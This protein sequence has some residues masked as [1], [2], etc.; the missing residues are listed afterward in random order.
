MKLLFFILIFI[1]TTA[2]ADVFYC[3]SSAVVGFSP[4]NGEYEEAVF[5]TSKFKAK[6]DFNKRTFVSNDL[7]LTD[8]ACTSIFTDGIT[9]VSN[10]Y[11]ININKKD[12]KFALS[13]A[14]GYVV[15]KK[16]TVSIS[17]G[18]CDKF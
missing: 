5:N 3:S 17:I 16:D 11:S 1:T 8:N 14:Y 7:S 10:G 4:T 15:G 13:K 9:C 12:F 18:T 6:I 2:N